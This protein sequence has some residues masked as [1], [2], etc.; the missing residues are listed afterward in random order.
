MILILEENKDFYL[1][2][3]LN[4]FVKISLLFVHFQEKNLMAMKTIRVVY[5]W[6]KF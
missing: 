4:M 2:L 6:K 3:F 5:F 1:L